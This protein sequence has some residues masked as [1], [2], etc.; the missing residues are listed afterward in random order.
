MVCRSFTA[1]LPMLGYRV[2]QK[3]DLERQK[4]V[5]G[6]VLR[7]LY[8]ASQGWTFEVIADLDSG[9]NYQLIDSV[10]QAVREAQ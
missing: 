3:A 9:V 10:R 1:R 5:T 6:I 4:Q 2:N 8:C 7:A